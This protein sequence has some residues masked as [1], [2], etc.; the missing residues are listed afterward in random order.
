MTQ[1]QPKIVMMK[2][3]LYTLAWLIAI[4][5]W[6]ASFYFLLSKH[7]YA[8]NVSIPEHGAHTFLFFGLAF[9][10]SCAQRRPNIAMTLAILYFFGGI[11]EVS[12]H[13]NP[14]RTCDP[15]DFM[16]DVV[17]STLGVFT[18]LG[19][20]ALLRWFLHFLQAQPVTDVPY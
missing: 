7:P 18:A 4:G 6:C 13:F 17:G 2:R 15:M 14:P 20:M 8:G 3:F 9:M 16:E 5:L 12:Q 10:T 19:W 1:R 11:T